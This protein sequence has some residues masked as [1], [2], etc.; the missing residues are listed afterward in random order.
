MSPGL[1]THCH[2][3]APDIY[4]H[5]CHRHLHH[6]ISK[7][8]IH[9]SIILCFRQEY[10]VH[11]HTCCDF[12]LL[13][14]TESCVLRKTS[15]QLC[16]FPHSTQSHLEVSA[17]AGK[18]DTPTNG[19]TWTFSPNLNINIHNQNAK[20]CLVSGQIGL[21]GLLGRTIAVTAGIC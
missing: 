5:H 11:S 6:D 2:T 14:K 12:K 13:K 4:C 7:L 1:I 15:G 20:G 3:F 10:F 16:L 8:P 17:T 21:P 9:S 19:S 18:L